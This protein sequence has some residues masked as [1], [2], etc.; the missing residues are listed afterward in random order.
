MRTLVVLGGLFLIGVAG[1]NESGSPSTAG[2]GSSRPTT[3]DPKNTAV[4]VRDRSE[5]TKTP[6]DQKENQGDINL[7][8]NIRK[9]VVD[10]EMSTD[11]HN[12]KIISQDGR[13]TLRGPVKSEDE[14][15]KIEAIAHDVAGKSN[16]DSELEIA[17]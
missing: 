4:N 2:P 12:V 3:V 8:A 1:C 10:T 5:A 17:P 7:T 16:V 13:V 14:K 6:I 15:A 9:R 11:A